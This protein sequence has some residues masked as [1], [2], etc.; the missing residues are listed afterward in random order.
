MTIEE[1]EGLW[2]ESLCITVPCCQLRSGSLEEHHTT[3][4]FEPGKIPVQA[5]CTWCSTVMHVTQVAG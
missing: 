2:L 1:A 3:V 5:V 4:H